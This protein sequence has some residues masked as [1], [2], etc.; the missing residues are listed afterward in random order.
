MLWEKFFWKSAEFLYLCFYEI[1]QHASDFYSQLQPIRSLD[2]ITPNTPVSLQQKL[3]K[4]KI[5]DFAKTHK[6]TKFTG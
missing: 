3:D 6:R 4:L 5:S 1:Q 2:T